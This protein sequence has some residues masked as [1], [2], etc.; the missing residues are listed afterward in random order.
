MLENSRVSRSKLVILHM[1]YPI[2]VYGSCFRE[3]IFQVLLNC[4]IG[5]PPFQLPF[6]LRLVWI[7]NQQDSICIL[8]ERRP[9]T[10]K[11]ACLPRMSRL[12][13]NIWMCGQGLT[14][15]SHC[16]PRAPP[17][18]WRCCQWLDSLL[19]TQTLRCAPP[20]SGDIHPLSSLLPLPGS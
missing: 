20:V 17:Q 5:V 9:T 3:A 18:L 8:P 6:V 15:C 2:P 7:V 4:K 16:S 19:Q 14:A 10:L 12:S 1:P 11:P 13:E